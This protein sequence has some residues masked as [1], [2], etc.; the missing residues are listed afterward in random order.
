M[1]ELF[2]SQAKEAIKT[3]DQEKVKQIAEMALS[4]GLEPAVI[5]EEGFI[6]GIKEVGELFESEEIFLPELIM[7]ADAMKVATDIC[8]KSIN[9]EA[10]TSKG[11]VL[12][13]TVKGDVHDIGKSIVESFLSANGFE[14]IDLGT[15]ISTQT[16]I[17][18][19]QELK[20]DVIATSAL[21]TTTMGYQ[22]DLEKAL[23]DQRLKDKFKTIVGGA[24]VTQNW[25]DKIGADAYAEDAA[26]AAVKIKE[27]LT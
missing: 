25:A 15:D 12:L 9:G 11:K 2:F 1:Q 14:V 3:A 26:G 17:D 13:G 16:F 27:L 23:M 6:A 19:A 5:L 4:S 21:L 7:A 20:V 10:L 24:P 18:K 22:E 8:N